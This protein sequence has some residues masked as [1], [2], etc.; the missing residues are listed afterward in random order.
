MSHVDDPYLIQGTEVLHNKHGI[1][2]KDELNAVESELAGNRIDDF[3]RNPPP[4][5]GVFGEQ[6]LRD[7]HKFIFQDTYF[8]KGEHEYPIAGEK[9]VMGMKKNTIPITLILITP[10]PM[11]ISINV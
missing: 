2:N 5:Q 7:I 4:V 3:D 9:R 11:A 1:T 6:H 8:A 10:I